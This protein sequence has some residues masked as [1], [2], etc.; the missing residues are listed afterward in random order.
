MKIRR[1]THSLRLIKEN[2]TY[3]LEQ[4][5]DLFGLDVTTVRRWVRDEG[6]E[7]IP[8]TRPYLVHSSMLKAFLHKKQSVRKQACGL[9]EAFCCKCRG[10]R[11]P[12][13]GTGSAI[14]LPNKCVRFQA[15]CATCG[16]TMNKLI[17]AVEWSGNHPLV[18]YIH[19]VPKQ[20][21]GVSLQHR[22]CHFQKEE[23]L[24]LN[25]IP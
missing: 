14:A 11:A 17:K 13:P 22:E 10:P 19:D 23:Q 5:A 25:L 7:R 9:A 4:I 21:N 16:S 3:T 24:C 8:K 12:A 6:L 20:H 2:Y 18:H 1:R 15:H